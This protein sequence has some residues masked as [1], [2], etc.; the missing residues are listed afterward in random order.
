MKAGIR[1]KLFLVSV[2]LIGFSLVIADLYLSRVLEQQLTERIREELLTK[3]RLVA[4]RVKAVGAESAL[5]DERLYDALADELGRLSGARVTLVRRDGTVAGDSEVETKD[6][7]SLENHA[8][9]PEISEA[10][11]SGEGDIMRYSTTLHQRMMYVA[12]PIISGQ[13][14][15]QSAI[16]TARVA[17]P[18]TAVD[19][20]LS[21][22][23]KTLIAAALLALALA[24]IASLS[25]ANVVSRSLRDITETAKRMASGNLSARTRA[26]GSDEVAALG[27]SLD[28]LAATLSASLEQ[29]RGERDLLSGILSSMNEGVLV[30]GKDRRILLVNRA[31]RDMLL[32]GPEAEGKNILH[33]V[34]NAELNRLLSDAERGDSAQTEIDLAG[35]KPRRAMVHA[36]TLREAPGGILAVFVD[37][38]ELRRLESVRRDFVANASHELRSPLTTI[39]AATE[40]LYSVKDDPVEAEKFIRIVERNAE[41]VEHLVSDMLE[42][43]RL[44]SRELVLHMEAIGLTTVVDRIQL[45]H[46]APAELKRFTV[47]NDIPPATRVLADQ[48]ALE[49]LLGN[50]VDNALKYCPPGATIRLEARDEEAMV[51]VSVS[52]T[53]PGI[54][55]QHLPRLFER[56]YRVDAGRSRE[57]GGT[58]LGLSIVKHLAEAMGGSV[59]VESQPGAGST[60]SFTLQRA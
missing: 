41:R 21:D 60:F 26:A 30:V 36:V 24:A 9:R 50:L 18:L 10:L 1:L 7:R 58:G 17:M 53:G 43:A 3:A 45:R 32:L 33:V 22:L 15:G 39:R 25:V 55:P 35:L 38:T 29:M 2:G 31:L 37:V 5:R 59:S 16:G 11:G 48:R 12:V 57:L 20:A 27:R 13:S 6:L 47:V 23:D 44:E 34:R 56:F 51:R 4:E 28:Q 54:A 42:I 52:D 40:T 19:Q 49:N 14:A 8:T 46:A